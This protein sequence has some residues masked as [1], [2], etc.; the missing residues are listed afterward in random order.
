MTDLPED[1]EYERRFAGV[2][3][4]YG[5]EAFRQYEHSHVMVIGI[6]GVGS[7]RLK[8]WHVPALLS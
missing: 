6:G 1:D 4:I 3:K 2:E 8:L 7:G 5:D